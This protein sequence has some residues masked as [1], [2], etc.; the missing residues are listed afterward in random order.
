ME[1]KHHFGG[2]VYIKET[3]FKA[4]EYGEKHTHN[5][6]HLSILVSGQAGI[7]VDDEVKIFT[8]PMIMTVEKG[9]FHQVMAIT[10]IVWHCIHATDCTD[11][12]LI[13]QEL[14]GG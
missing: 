9:K 8:G 3:H 12:A 2:G 14:E 6:A 11:A 7:Q 4:G 5:F 1:I 13:D 10:D